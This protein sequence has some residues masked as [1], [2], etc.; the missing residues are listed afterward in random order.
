[1]RTL[2]EVEPPTNPTCTN[3]NV[4]MRLFGVEDHSIIK[5]AK[6]LTYFCPRCEA[7]GTEIVPNFRTE[8]ENRL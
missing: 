8:F 5:R 1:M 7:V 6:L 3:C 4:T 2:I